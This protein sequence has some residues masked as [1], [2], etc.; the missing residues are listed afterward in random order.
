M[1]PSPVRGGRIPHARRHGRRGAAG[2]TY[3]E[4]LVTMIVLTILAGAV[5]PIARTAI[6]REKEIELRQ[7]LRKIR[8]AIDQYKDF[9]DQGVIQKEGI[10]SECYP[11]ELE[12][13]VEGVPQVGTIDK[14]LKFLRRIP[15]DPFTNTTEW[16]LRSYQDDPDSTSWGRQNVYDVFTQFD[17]TALDGSRY[18]EW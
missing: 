16:G 9:C 15:K 14:K 5:I 6:R 12:Q 18:Q 10:D 13:L 1:K 7:A 2:L 11:T 8:T 4:V 17:G 3:V